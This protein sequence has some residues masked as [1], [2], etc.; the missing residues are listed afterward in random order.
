MRKMLDALVKAATDAFCEKLAGV[1]LH[2]S[3]AMGCFHKD[4]S[5]IDILYVVS[6][7]L[8]DD[9]KLAFMREIVRLNA[10]AP[11]KGIEMS[12]VHEKDMKPFVHPAPFLLH[13]SNAHIDRY[14]RSPCE[15]IARMKGTDRDLAAHVMIVNHYGV[16]LYGKEIPE[17]FGP[18]P[19]E[20]Y[21]DALFYDI[22][23]AREDIKENP[24]YVTHS[25]SRILAYVSEGKC[26]SKRDGALWAA[27][28]VN[29]KYRGLISD[30][31]RAYETEETAV[32][33]PAHA[34]FADEMLREIG[35][36]TK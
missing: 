3:L 11:K 10:D 2:G 1:Y 36:Y 25:L 22:E 34:E 19:K 5:D 23:N 13:F 20:A 30:A 7:M 32:Y 15:Y 16:R 33:T 4:K 28:H 17:V 18:V 26:L 21:L 9:E 6:Q 14:T 31:L 8:T 29:E 12:V 24:M 35:K 27:E